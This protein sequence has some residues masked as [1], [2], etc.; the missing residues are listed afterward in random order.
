MR[1]VGVIGTSG[2][3]AVAVTP[4]VAGDIPSLYVSGVTFAGTSPNPVAAGM[5]PVN[6]NAPWASAQLTPTGTNGFTAPDLG[7]RIVSWGLKVRYTGTTLNQSG[8]TFCLTSADH[9]DLSG[10][11]I[12]TIANQAETSVEAFGRKDCLVCGGS[13]TSSEME[14]GMD[15]ASSQM[16][17]M[18]AGGTSGASLSYSAAMAEILYPCSQGYNEQN[19]NATVVVPGS[20]QTMRLP[21]VPTCVLMSGVAGQSFYY[22]YVV[23]LEYVGLLASAFLSPNHVDSQSAQIVRAAADSVPLAKQAAPHKSFFTLMKE[24]MKK[25]LRALAPYAKEVAVTAAMALVA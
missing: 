14:Y 23:H 10:Y 21:A 25:G 12:N 24:E 17:V 5:T 9:S 1:G 20:A 2:C 11:T 18:A 19:P 16:M 3:G 13:A 8:Q 22:E 4:C 15:R 6:V 7:G